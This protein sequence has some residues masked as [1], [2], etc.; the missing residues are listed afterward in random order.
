MFKFFV[1]NFFTAKISGSTVLVYT[2]AEPPL[3]T[4]LSMDHLEKIIDNLED[5]QELI[6]TRLGAVEDS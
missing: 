6:L 1:E 4:A 5:R 3:D 2:Y